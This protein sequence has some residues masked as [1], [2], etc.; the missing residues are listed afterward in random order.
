MFAVY[1]T[2]ITSLKYLIINLI[3]LYIVV[4]INQCI[5]ISY[6]NFLYFHTFA[7]FVLFLS[8]DSL[9]TRRREMFNILCAI[10]LLAVIFSFF[11]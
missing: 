6:L 5:V 9:C 3:S 4:L 8:G 7:L 2:T 1:S 11:T 10:F